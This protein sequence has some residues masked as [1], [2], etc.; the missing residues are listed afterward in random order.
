MKK[1]CILFDI[2]DITP[3][4]DKTQDTWEGIQC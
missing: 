3:M 1:F 4:C 2:D